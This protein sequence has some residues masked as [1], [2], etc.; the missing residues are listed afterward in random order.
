MSRWPNKITG[1]NAGG[2]RRLAMRTRRAARIAQFNRSAR[3]GA[4]VLARLG[5]IR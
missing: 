2:P 1:A 4:W 5:C 3:S